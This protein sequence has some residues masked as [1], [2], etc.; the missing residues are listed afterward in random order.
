MLETWMGGTVLFPTDRWTYLLS[1]EK[2][3]RIESIGTESWLYPDRLR[4]AS[5]EVW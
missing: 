1:E 5:A 4:C 2:T 3:K